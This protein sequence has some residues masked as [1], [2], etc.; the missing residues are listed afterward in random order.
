MADCACDRLGMA[1][2]KLCPEGLRLYKAQIEAY[3][4]IDANKPNSQQEYRQAREAYR[5]HVGTE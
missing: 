1:D 5:A 4:A 2:E 3:L